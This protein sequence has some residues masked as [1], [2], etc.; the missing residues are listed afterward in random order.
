[1]R[2]T[3]FYHRIFIQN[4]FVLIHAICSMPIEHQLHWLLHDKTWCFLRLKVQPLCRCVWEQNNNKRYK[5]SRLNTPIY[6]V[7]W[8]RS[9]EGHG[10]FQTT[11]L[12]IRSRWTHQKAMPI[13]STTSIPL[14]GRLA[15]PRIW[16]W[17][18]WEKVLVQIQARIISQW[19]YWCFP[20]T[21]WDGTNLCPSLT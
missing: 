20:W 12:N 7:F 4:C 14:L 19:F 1:M 9:I 3:G 5:G 21:L 13:G 10:G 15:M 16:P 18:F 8:H 11:W 2:I 17:F 6:G